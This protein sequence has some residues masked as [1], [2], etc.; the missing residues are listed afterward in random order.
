MGEF[1]DQMG[2]L[3][4]NT[5]SPDQNIRCVLQNSDKRVVSSFAGDSYDSYRVEDLEH[6]LAA[7]VRLTFIGRES[8]RR[9]AFSKATGK[10]Y[11]ERDLVEQPDARWRRYIEE[12][13]NCEYEG[14][15]AGESVCMVTQGLRD[16]DVRI[17]EES[18]DQLSEPE[19]NR[20]FQSAA[21]DLF[22]DYRQITKELESKHF[23][24]SY[25]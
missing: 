23:S 20:E 24:P 15:S 11:E 10:N 18:L 2:R 9:A 8:G 3:V 12:R 6:Q 4:V 22:A 5:V 1:A 7:M 14:L 25:S 16:W 17:Q 21:S 13:D 19:F